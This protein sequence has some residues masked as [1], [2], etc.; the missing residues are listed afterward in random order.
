MA[1][2][3]NSHAATDPINSS[4]KVNS[5]CLLND[6]KSVCLDIIKNCKMK[7]L[8]EAIN[9]VDQIDNWL[10][11]LDKTEG[12]IHAVKEMINIMQL[13]QKANKLIASKKFPI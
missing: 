4:Y 10:D 12:D 2:A 8:D 6:I 9:Q 13:V 5:L 3:N 7:N 11:E 1:T